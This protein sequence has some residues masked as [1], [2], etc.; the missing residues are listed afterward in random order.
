MKQKILFVYLFMVTSIPMVFSQEKIS[1]EKLLE[2]FTILEKAI[3]TVHPGLYKYHNEEFVENNFKS[4]K[5]KLQKDLT[6]EEAY[7]AFSVFVANVKCGH[8]LVNPY[9][10]SSVVNEQIFN[11]ANKLPFTFQVVN[12]RMIL[13]KNLSDEK[14]LKQGMEILAING[15]KTSAIID[16]LLSVASGDGSNMGQRNANLQ[17]TGVGKY[18]DVDIYFPLFFPPENGLYKV[19]I[20]SLQND[21]IE[22]FLLKAIS[23]KKRVEKI[24]SK[25]GTV[26]NTYDDL[27]SYKIMDDKIGYLK[28]GTFVVWKMEMNWKKFIDAAFKSFKENK[29]TDVI[30]DIRG[31]GGGMDAVS[32]Y[33][34]KYLLEENAFMPRNR[35]KVKYEKI[36]AEL[37]PYL[38]TWEKS[39]YDFSGKV[40]PDPTAPGYFVFNKAKLNGKKIKG[41]RKAIKAKKWL[42]VDGANSSATF[43]LA[44]FMKENKVATLVGEM[45][46]GNKKGINGGGIFFLNLPNSKIEIDIPIY[47]NYPLTE[48][49]DAG[50]IPDVIIEKKVEDVVE[51]RD[52]ALEYILKN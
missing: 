35:F 19:K 20:K 30:I 43:Y 12:K 2:D 14:G 39:F 34:R 46:G 24:E 41:K 5:S 51:G 8:T 7:L 3:Y 40:S 48:Q 42:L 32:F 17:L 11:A 47:G 50:V 23:R 13:E 15:V 16:S 18:E 21:S 36:P 10:Q 44:D 25:Y 22:E 27:W 49:S 9:N 28:L 29:V 37:R 52:A 6:L 33:L 45:T 1:S 38:S 31:N 4:L 26:P